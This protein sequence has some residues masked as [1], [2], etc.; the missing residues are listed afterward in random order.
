MKYMLLIYGNEELWQSFPEEEFAK[1][2][3][4]TDALQQELR[5]SG[6]FVGAWGVADQVQA[7][8][9][10]LV[11]GVPAVT[12]GPYIE[13]KEYL[14]SVD[15]ID[16][17]SLGALSRSPPGCPSPASGRSR[18]GRSCTRRL[19]RCEAPTP[20]PRTCCAGW[21]RG[22]SAP[23]RRYGH[24]DASEGGA[25]GS[26]GGALLRACPATRRV[27]DDG[28][29]RRLIDRLRSDEARRRREDA[30]AAG[31]GRPWVAPGPGDTPGGEGS[32]DGDDVDI[33]NV[34]GTGGRTDG[35][36]STPATR[37]S[38]TTRWP[39]SSCAA[40]RRCRRRRSWP[41]PA[42]RGRPDDR[43]D[44]ALFLVPEATMAQRISRAKQRIRAT[45]A[46]FQPPARTSARAAAGGPACAVP[47]VQRG[48]RGHR[49]ARPATARPDLRRSGWPACT[50]WC[51]TTARRR[52][53]WR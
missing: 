31:P 17:D 11:D 29:P 33:A 15:I 10:R 20:A 34:I 38:A 25:G 7:K 16:C 40:I 50:A 26:A 22:S 45:G 32:G 1:V 28:P 47:D 39:C 5:E 27:A 3:Q 48:L 19:P 52:G 12:D 53:C 42:G 4:E 46:H 36:G 51:R 24:F 44:R 21:P 9:V 41:H 49:G 14:G 23:S 35:P 8:C 18:C 43:R 37:P 30:G 2:I 6:E 13:A